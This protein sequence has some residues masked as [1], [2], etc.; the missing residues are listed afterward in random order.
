MSLE[1]HH[2]NIAV[3]DL[4]IASQKFSALLDCKPMRA[5]LPQRKATTARFQ[6][7][8]VWLV[9]V[10]PTCQTSPI[11]GYLAQRGEG[12]F[13]LSFTADALDEKLATLER[14]G[15]ITPQS[16]RRTGLDNWQIQDIDIGYTFDLVLQLCQPK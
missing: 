5:E 9:L 12:V 16:D 10:A 8:S 14:D 3:R 4:N 6:C 13:L 11:N 7:G 15:A 1:I 2:I